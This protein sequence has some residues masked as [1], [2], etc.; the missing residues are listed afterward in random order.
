MRKHFLKTVAAVT[1]ATI[2]LTLGSSGAFAENSTNKADS[3]EIT[4][5]K[6]V[7]SVDDETMAMH[8]AYMQAFEEAYKK[9]LMKKRR[10]SIG[11]SLKEILQVMKEATNLLNLRAL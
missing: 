1:A 2:V 5:D 3:P 8:N 9:L 11:I 6:F 7:I 10:R 4:A